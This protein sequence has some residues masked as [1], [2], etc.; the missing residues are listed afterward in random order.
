M[1]SLGLIFDSHS[2][3][4]DSAHGCLVVSI[5]GTQVTHGAYS[6]IW[7]YSQAASGIGTLTLRKNGWFSFNTVGEAP[8]TLATTAIAVP[9][10]RTLATTDV[11][12]YRLLCHHRLHAR[13]PILLSIRSSAYSILARPCAH[14][15]TNL[16]TLAPFPWIPPH[17]RTLTAHPS[18]WSSKCRTPAVPDCAP[19][20]DSSAENLFETARDA[21]PS[22]TPAQELVVRLNVQSSVRGWVRCELRDAS[23]GTTIPGYDLNSSVTILAQNALSAPLRWQSV[24]SGLVAPGELVTLHFEA[25]F[26]KLFSFELVWE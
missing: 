19:V 9:P 10:R 22:S 4:C 3:C 11:L 6:N 17:V 2:C 12:P 26:S 14:A 7:N 16:R 20:L 24:R 5:S 15:R 13:P 23:S 18:T 25:T 1:T 8:A 21:T